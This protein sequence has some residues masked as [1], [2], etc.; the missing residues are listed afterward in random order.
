MPRL[1]VVN[2]CG[3]EIA[4]EGQAGRSLMEL[5]RDNG[6][7]DLQALCG[8]SCSCATCHV[9]VDPAFM[10]KLPEMS[11]QENDMLDC[12]EDRRENSRLS[13]QLKMSETLDG[14]RVTV[15]PV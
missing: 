4:L 10:G 15:A 12:T 9:W 13:C 6:V 2:T 14:L 1:I 11:S 7:D 5:M 8:G 3:E